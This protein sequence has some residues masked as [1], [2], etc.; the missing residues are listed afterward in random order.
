MKTE[1]QTEDKAAMSLV[2]PHCWEP[3]G[4]GRGKEEFCPRNFGGSMAC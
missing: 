1:A 3:P 4:S 2:M